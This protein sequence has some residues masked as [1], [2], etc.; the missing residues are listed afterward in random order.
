[1][2]KKTIIDDEDATGGVRLISC[3]LWIAFGSAK[4]AIHEI[5]EHECAFRLRLPLEG[6]GRTHSKGLSL[7]RRIRLMEPN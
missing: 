2:T 3:Y 6:G 5:H 1:M 4:K 7:L